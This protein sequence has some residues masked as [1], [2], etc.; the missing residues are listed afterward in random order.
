MYNLVNSFSTGEIKLRPKKRIQQ[1]YTI[2]LKDTKVCSIDYATGH[3]EFYNRN[4]IPF[5]LYFDD[6]DQQNNLV[7]FN[8]WCANRVLSLDREYAKALL[9]SCGLRQATTDKDRAAIA[10]KYSC[11]SLKDFY[12]VAISESQQWS[13]INLFDNSLSNAIVDVA[14]SGKNL[15]VTNAYLLASDLSTDGVFP[16]AWYRSD[17][18]L[19]LYK[20]DRNGSV[21]KEVQASRLLR[22]L[23]FNVLQYHKTIYHN[24]VVSVSK[25]F[26]SKDVGY[27][28]AGDLT[29][30]YDFDVHYYEY[31]MMNLCD[32]LVGN[33][34]RHQDNWGFLFNDQRELIG[35]APIFDFNH[36]FEATT[37]TVC[38]PEQLDGN[39]VTQCEVAKYVKK[40]YNVK[41]TRLSGTDPYTEY[42][43]NRINKLSEG[44][45]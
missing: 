11:L 37:D 1:I 2:M 25:C 40:K 10:L 16:K 5:D 45:L 28:T 30:N 34:D 32:Y 19:L 41:L 29:Q 15:T 23:G 21:D 31:D 44:V 9:N 22:Q 24:Q 7:V 4:L 14:L 18:G 42:I 6:E 20:G 35:F 39:T 17:S 33:V 13:R 8:W 38:L 3:V 27:V 36:A 26:T 12:W 43:N